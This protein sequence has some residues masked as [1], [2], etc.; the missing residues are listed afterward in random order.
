[1]IIS[2]V[3]KYIF[4][5]L[6][7]SASSAIS[8][9][10]VTF[11]EG[12]SILSKHANIPDFIEAFGKDKNLKDYLVFCVYRDP[13]DISITYFNKL[14]SDPYNVLTDTN[15]FEENGGWVNKRQRKFHQL[16]KK[17]NYS[18]Q[19][20]LK[21][22]Y[23]FP[24]DSCYSMNRKFIND[25]INFNNLQYD[26]SRILNRMNIKK[27]RDIPIFN[28][29][30]NKVEHNINKDLKNKVFDSFYKFNEI[31]TDY[32]PNFFNYCLYLSFQKIRFERWK[33]R[34]RNLRN[35]KFPTDIE[36]LK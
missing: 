5:G 6:P 20:F 29:T 16:I 12:K 15:S 14:K 26:F 11:Y 19:E 35:K 8:R 25:E 33:L 4:I 27:V 31:K 17:N 18:F 22:Y 30:E 7:F 21:K 23:L 10:L 2:D 1:M 28:K 36:K 13:I 9:E 32:N 3:N 24:Y 34:D